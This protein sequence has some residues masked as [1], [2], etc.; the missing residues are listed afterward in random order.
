MLTGLLLLAAAQARTPY[1]PVAGLDMGTHTLYQFAV[2]SD[3]ESLTYNVYQPQGA[4]YS[5]TMI[6]DAVRAS[7]E[8][9][10]REIRAI[11]PGATPCVR[12]MLDIY[13]IAESALNDVARFPARFVG[14]PSEGRGP[15]WGY[16]DPNAATGLEVIVVSAHGAVEDRRILVHEIA[17]RWYA[18]YCMDRY[19]TMTSEEFAVGVAGG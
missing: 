3:G 5:T 1:V 16:Y 18:A 14:N 13:E 15:L 17:H 8:E 11:A 12:R 6:A 4:A 10:L 9:S 7:S 2:L 19:T